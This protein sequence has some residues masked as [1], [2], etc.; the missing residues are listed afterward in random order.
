MKSSFASF[1]RQK[2]VK[3]TAELE[4]ELNA[5]YAF[6]A[7]TEAGANLVPLA[8]PELQGLQNLGNSCY[9]NS[10]CQTLFSGSIPELSQKYS[11]KNIMNHALYKSISAKDAASNV[12]CQAVKMTNALTSGNFVGP[13]PESATVTDSASE[14][15]N[16]KYRLAPRMFK[17][18]FAKGHCDF[19]TGQQQDAVHYLQH[20]LEVL[21]KAESEYALPAEDTNQSP[22]SHL[23]AY[24]TVSRLVCSEDN[25]VKYKTNSLE[26]VLSLSIPMDKIEEMPPDQKRHKSETTEDIKTAEKQ[27]VPSIQFKSCFDSWIAP[28]SIQDM[29]WPHLQNATFPATN[30]NKFETFPPYLFVSLQRYRLGADWVPE[31]LEVN[32]EVPEEIDLNE[33]K[34]KGPMSGESL[35]TEEIE[36]EASSEDTAT[37]T[38][39]I[40]SE[41]ALDQLSAMGFSVN[42]CKRALLAVGGSD[43]ESAM[44]WIFEHNMDPDFNDPPNEEQG[45]SSTSGIDESVVD[46]LVNSL[47]C[48]TS[49]QVRAA[50][51]ECESD[52][53]RAA[54]WLFSNMVSFLQCPKLL[55]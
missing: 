26:T 32:V 4:V 3:S 41:S 12:L 36:K 44:N 20:I 27:D 48:F 24:Q 52:A 50:L 33:Y 5:T 54:D 43:V 6:D 31:K 19:V 10:V 23:F 45:S 46:T 35:I 42:G 39:T 53:A 2:T 47:G 30:Q 14:S 34:S 25:M 38:K 7:I 22:S 51:E 40:I 1:P 18:A 15:T 49:D 29:K 8:G 37:A 9:M 55:F 16:P 13:L 28:T 17:N 11:S 21:D